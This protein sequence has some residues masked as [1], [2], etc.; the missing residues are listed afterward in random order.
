MRTT[1][2]ALAATSLFALSAPALAQEAGAPGAAG[3]SGSMSGSNP[4]TS[5]P[6]YYSDGP[7]YDRYDRGPGPSAEYPD[8]P[9]YRDDGYMN[10]G[11]AAAPDYAPGY[12][13]G[14]SDDNGGYGPG[15]V[16]PGPGY[17]MDS[18]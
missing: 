18:R 15:R 8:G 7:M 17:N 11:R 14:P 16:S 3:V 5:Y 1:L 10:E 6:G 4:G 13:N 12:D 9:R 2:F